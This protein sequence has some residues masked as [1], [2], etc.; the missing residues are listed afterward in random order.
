MVAITNTK[1]KSND[2]LILEGLAEVIADVV[3]KAIDEKLPSAIENA[4]N[5]RGGGKPQVNQRQPGSFKLPK[6]D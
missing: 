3:T 5:A 1:P 2:D 6:G 4:L